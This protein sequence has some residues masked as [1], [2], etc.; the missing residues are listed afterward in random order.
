[1]RSK[2]ERQFIEPRLALNPQLGWPGVFGAQK[3]A[4]SSQ[5]EASS[6]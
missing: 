2:H 1:M 3:H 4:A 6:F 5:K